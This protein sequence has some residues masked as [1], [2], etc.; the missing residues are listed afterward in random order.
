MRRVLVYAHI[1]AKPLLSQFKRTA[2]VIVSDNILMGNCLDCV[3]E[4]RLKGHKAKANK[5][6]LSVRERS[7]TYPYAE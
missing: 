3:A 2:S 6:S 5:H 1:K 4:R 7:I